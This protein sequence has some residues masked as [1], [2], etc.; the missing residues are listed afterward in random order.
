MTTQTR[1]SGHIIETG[2]AH[3]GRT[4][5]PDF[6]AGEGL[7]LFIAVPTY[8][9]TIVEREREIRALHLGR[10]APQD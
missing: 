4:A 9:E 8:A 6:E 7:S 3:S 2:Y 10:Q 5:H 1:E